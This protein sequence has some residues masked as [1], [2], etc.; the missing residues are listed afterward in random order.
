MVSTSRAARHQ[1]QGFK[2]QRADKDDF[3]E[4]PDSATYRHQHTLPRL[5]IPSL[6]STAQK[7]L[8]STRPFVSDLSPKAP[9][10]SDEHPTKAY[11]ATK[12]AVKEF[13]ESPLVRELQQRLQEHAKGKDSWLIDW[14]NTGSYFG[15]CR[16][17]LPSLI[18]AD[19]LPLQATAIQ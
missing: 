2:P 8:D 1:Q 7:Y 17:L 5:P 12:A 11:L 14:F 16:L 19:C 9:V 15:G 3:A 18:L 4:S 10:A 13:V 6:E